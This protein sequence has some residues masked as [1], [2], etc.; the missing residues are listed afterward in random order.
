MNRRVLPWAL[1]LAVSGPL[2]AQTSSDPVRSQIEAARLGAGYA[3]I[4]NLAATPDFSAARYRVGSAE[5]K[6]ELDVLR[7]PYQSRWIA[8]SDDADL[9]WRVAG[10]YLQL[11]QDLPIVAGDPSLGDIASKWSAYSASGGLLARIRLGS[12]FTLE[13]ALDVGVARLDNG[14]SYNGIAF[15]LQPLLDGIL[16]NWHTNAWLATPSLALAWTTGNAEGRATVRGHVARSWISTFDATDPIQEFTEA[17]NSYSVRAEY[18]KA[19]AWQAFDR[20]LGWIAYASY[21]GFFGANRN[22]L[23]FTSVTELGGGLETPL[24]P[25]GQRPERLR[26][27]AGY[28]FGPDVTGWSVGLSLQY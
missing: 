10:G 7:L 17:A 12:G 11:K 20:P 13:P 24:A 23:G 3:Q 14:A 2:A 16:F 28:L 5:P 26:L 19:N 6:L 18:A 1:L 4:I 22:A 8:L 9:Y 15:G 21:A 25:D 27:S